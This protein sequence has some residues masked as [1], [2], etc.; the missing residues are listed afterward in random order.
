MIDKDKD[1]FGFSVK[2]WIFLLVICGVLF[3]FLVIGSSIYSHRSPEVVEENKNGGKVVLNYSTQTNTFTI[4]DAVPTTDAIGSKTMTA[5]QYFDFSVDVDVS[6]ASKVEYELSIVKNEKKS[7]ISDDDIMIY[8]EKE[9]DGSYDAVF[10]PEAFEPIDEVS[11]VGSLKDSMILVN[12]KKIKSGID[13]Y[14]LRMWV[15]EKSTSLKGTYSVSV[16]VHAIAK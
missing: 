11:L 16:E 13:H 3:L 2:F 9:N 7:S 10:G 1:L 5:G 12:T 6:E 8:L 14:R 15:S 4:L